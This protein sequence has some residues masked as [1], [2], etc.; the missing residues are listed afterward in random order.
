MRLAFLDCQ[1]AFEAMPRVIEIMGEE[2]NWSKERKER[3]RLETVEFLKTMGLGM[4]T[5]YQAIFSKEELVKYKKEFSQCDIDGDG[6]ISVQDISMLMKR[7]KKTS[8][9]DLI[10]KMIEEIDQ[11]KNGFIEFNE[12][13]EIIGNVG[14]SEDKSKFAQFVDENFHHIPAERSGGG[15]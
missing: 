9:V 14:E 8:D 15:V 4:I 1:S 2:L 7:L 13:L 10:R 6:R 12:F 3:E 5:P 11:N